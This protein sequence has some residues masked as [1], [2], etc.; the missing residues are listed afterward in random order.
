SKSH[1]AGLGRRAGLARV[2]NSVER[3]RSAENQRQISPATR[4][5]ISP[6]HSTNPA[7]RPLQCE[8]AR[9]NRTKADRS[10]IPPSPDYGQAGRTR[11]GAPRRTTAFSSAP[12]SF[13]G[14]T[15]RRQRR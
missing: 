2:S 15:R 11:H 6:G 13:G 3:D 5:T 1:A 9:K 12:D 8:Y 10:G 4:T 14:A 7:A